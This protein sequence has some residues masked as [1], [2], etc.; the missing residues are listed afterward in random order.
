MDDL[1]T[2]ASKDAAHYEMLR[3]I[4]TLER[5]QIAADIMIKDFQHRLGVFEAHMDTSF[6]DMTREM[7]IS[8][9]AVN[10]KLEEVKA[11][12][13]DWATV[14]GTMKW[15]AGIVAALAGGMWAVFV[16]AVD[17]FKK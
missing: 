14:R 9:V 17:H 2:P 8:F 5:W 10:D 11:D 3:R 12:Q 6:A 13:R 15:L 1:R 4:D 7:R 16:F